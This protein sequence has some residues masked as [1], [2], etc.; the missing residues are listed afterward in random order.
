MMKKNVLLLM[1]VLLGTTSNMIA[2][3]VNNESANQYVTNALI[4]ADVSNDSATLL[5]CIDNLKRIH[6]F[7]PNNWL[8]TYYQDFYSLRYALLYNKD[9]NYSLLEEV[10]ESLSEMEY[11]EDADLSEIYTLYGFY[12]YVSLCNDPKQEINACNDE[13]MKWCDKAIQLNPQNPRPRLLKI[14]FKQTASK[15]LGVKAKDESEEI[16]KIKELF[17]NDSV[18]VPNPA[19]G[20]ELLSMITNN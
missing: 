2:A 19:W 9:K 12:N 6:R 17:K 11:D 1:F 14:L 7:F 3:D 20:K 18:T 4:K 16:A 8:A 5:T 13:I 15:I 10:K